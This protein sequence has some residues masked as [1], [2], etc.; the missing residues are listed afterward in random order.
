MKLL[1]SKFKWI[2]L[3][4]LV[5]SLILGLLILYKDFSFSF[6]NL[7]QRVARPNELDLGD[8]N[9]TNEVALSGIIIGLMM[10]AF[11]REKHEDEFINRLRLESL[12]WSVIINYVLL[13]IATWFINGAGFLQVMVYNMLTV[14]VIFIVYFHV[15]LLKIKN[16]A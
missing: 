13:L 10:I 4:I 6:L 12:Q 11:S 1:P 7:P 8:H 3:T 9:L 2:G 5:P 15:M 14:L 16:Q